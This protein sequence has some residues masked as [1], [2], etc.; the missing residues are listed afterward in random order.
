VPER[1]AEGPRWLQRFAIWHSAKHFWWRRT[2]HES[3]VIS[4]PRLCV[5]WCTLG[6]EW[7]QTLPL[8]K[9]LS[10]FVSTTFNSRLNS[11]EINCLEIDDALYVDQQYDLWAQ[12]FSQKM[13]ALCLIIGSLTSNNSHISF[14]PNPWIQMWRLFRRFLFYHL[15]ESSRELL[16]TFHPSS[17]SVSQIPSFS[18]SSVPS[19]LFH[20]S[21]WIW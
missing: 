21:S 8:R 6:R 20:V 4:Q 12:S 19:K 3:R 11:V 5:F 7:I 9:R 14:C 18:E 2:S 10:T 16:W 15:H 17:N 13:P 1:Y